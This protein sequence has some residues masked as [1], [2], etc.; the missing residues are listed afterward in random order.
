[1]ITIMFAC[2]FMFRHIFHTQL[3]I[4]L[5]PKSD[6][7]VDSENIPAQVHDKFFKIIFRNVDFI[8][9][10][11]RVS[12]PDD[13][14]DII[15]WSTLTLQPTAIPTARLG[16]RH[17]DLVFSVKVKSINEPAYIVLLFEHKSYNDSNLL[18]QVTQNQFLMY[19][20]EDFKSLII[21]IV[22]FQ[23]DSDFSGGVEFID[24]FPEL[25]DKHRKILTRYSVN[26][27]CVLIDINEIERRGLAR[28][29]NID[30]VV[31]AMSMMSNRSKVREAG[32]S[33]VRELSTRVKSVPIKHQPKVLGLS[34]EYVFSYNVDITAG[35]ILNE[36]ETPE[37]HQMIHSA[38]KFIRQEG[39]SEGLQKG[40]VEGISE[41]LQKG[42]VEGMVEVA[43][44]MLRKGVD[45][46]T[47]ADYTQLSRSKVQEIRREANKDSGR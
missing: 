5:M 17:A 38:V 45:P 28:Q 7:S 34:Y 44:N 26:F 31:W 33:M 4:R 46:E 12:I 42:R 18:R 40:R 23:S 41:G 36:A 3:G 14:F 27:R 25:S 29:T 43:K 15:D 35:D 32:L 37:E 13:L 21:P 10:L 19:L 11:I 47:V 6:K 22:V 39:L 9:S 16:E 8:I 2:Q 24:L 20:H 30:A 1:M